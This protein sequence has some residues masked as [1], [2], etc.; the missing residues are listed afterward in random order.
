MTAGF[1]V[2]IIKQITSRT[3]SKPYLEFLQSL[4]K[5][6]F[7]KNQSESWTGFIEPRVYCAW[8]NTQ[9][10]FG[11]LQFIYTTNHSHDQA[12][13]FCSNVMKSWGTAASWCFL[14]GLCSQW[15][16]YWGRSS[17]KWV[18]WPL[19]IYRSQAHFHPKGDRL[20]SPPQPIQSIKNAEQQSF[21]SA[22]AHVSTD[23]E[24]T[25]RKAQ[26]VFNYVI[27]YYAEQRKTIMRHV[28]TWKVD[29]EVDLTV[30]EIK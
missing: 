10:K 7:I 20:N 1:V 4:T 28:N 15:P 19:R 8:L 3:L 24:N 16:L 2:S 17:L 26:D 6:W 13:F 22:V 14:V 29:H 11:S 21:C 30:V 18:Q 9:L 5:G 23:S 27:K 25:L 12:S